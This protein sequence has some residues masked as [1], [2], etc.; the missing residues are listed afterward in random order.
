M[1]DESVLVTAARKSRSELLE[2]QK[3]LCIKATKFSIEEMDELMYMATV[4]AE[5]KAE[6]RIS[7]R[8]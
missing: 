6:L 4:K 1:N 3:V 7:S 8:D 2:E 5:A